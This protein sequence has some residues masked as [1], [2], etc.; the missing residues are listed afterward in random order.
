MS[1]RHVAIPFAFNSISRRLGPLASKNKLGNFDCLMN[2][3]KAFFGVVYRAKDVELDRV[4]ALK[5]PRAFA[6]SGDEEAERFF[7]EARSA[8]QLQ[9]P[10]IV[11]VFE[12]GRFEDVPNIAS[13]YVEGITLAD[14]ISGKRFGIVSAAKLIAQV[15]DALNYS[16]ARRVV[17]RD[18]KPSN[19]ML[20]TD[21][22]PR[23][24]DFGVAKRDAGDVTMTQEGQ[25]LGTPVYMSPEQ[26]SGQGH[27]VDGRCDIFSLGVVLYQLLTGELPFRGNKHM[28]LHQ[29]M[30]EEPMPPRSLNDRIPWDIQTICLKA[31]E[32]SPTAR[33]Q[34]AGEFRDD[35]IRFTKGMT[36]YAKPVG[37]LGNAWRWY[38]RNANAIVVTAGGYTV[39]LSL[40]MT[41]WNGLGFLFV[42]IGVHPGNR[43]II[44]ELAAQA[45]I[46]NP[47]MFMVGI[48]TVRNQFW[49]ISIGMCIATFWTFLTAFAMLK[50][51]LPWA[52]LEVMH[53]GKSDAFFHSQFFTLV[54]LLSAIAMILY[55]SAFSSRLRWEPWLGDNRIK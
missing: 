38:Y 43:Q 44:F 8:A 25:I 48:N 11:P 22:V 2:W 14:A 23:L 9:H 5:I 27:D 6:F 42:S 20:T 21:L 12:A 47:I 50:I 53:G 10:N 4:V 54:F 15:A 32:K 49:A 28:V 24:M 35:L 29:V 55:A 16:H 13:E 1:V 19:I 18:I 26:A 30:R 33:Y 3:V 7:R 40:V 31:M 46:V 52:R 34:T 45:F 36:I 37:Q 39:I 51:N 41:I 17:H